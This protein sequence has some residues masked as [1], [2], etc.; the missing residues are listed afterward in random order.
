M[1]Y[2]HDP[3]GENPRNLVVNEQHILTAEN[4][5]DF[6]TVIPKFAPFF[7]NNFSLVFRHAAT[8]HEEPLKLGKDY[9]F[10]HLFAEASKSIGKPV[11][12][13]VTF[14]KPGLRGTLLLK[15]YQSLG[16]DWILDT[17]RIQAILADRI[18]NPRT[19][20]WD[21]V[22]NLPYRYPVINHDFNIRDFVGM[23]NVQ[24]VLMR[25]ESLLRQQT[26]AGLQEH[27]DDRENPHGVTKHQVQLGNVLNL[28]ILNATTGRTD[29]SD[30]FYVT[31]RGVRAIVNHELKEPF[32]RFVARRDNPNQVTAE[33]VNSFTKEQ[34]TALLANYLIKTAAA[35]DTFRFDNKTA[36]QFKTWV[37]EG[38][39]SNA[40]RLDGLSLSQVISRIQNS[41][42]NNAATLEGRNSQELKSWVL[43]GTAA[44]STRAYGLDRDGLYRW[45]G[46]QVWNAATLAGKDLDTI[47]AEISAGTSENATKLNG[48]T[49]DQLLQRFVRAAGINAETLA[50]LTLDGVIERV[51]QHLADHGTVRNATRFNGKTWDEVKAELAPPS[52][53]I[54][55]ATLEGKN[56]AQIKQ[57]VQNAIS[58]DAGT[59]NGQ[60]AEQII[61]AALS[62]QNRDALSLQGKSFSQVM[63]A[64]AASTVDNSNRLGGQ[65]LDQVKRTILNSVDDVVNPVRYH[66][67]WVAF[68]NVFPLIRFQV[69]NSAEHTGYFLAPKLL[70][71]GF[72]FLDNLKSYSADNS[73]D[74]EV[75]VVLN[76]SGGQDALAANAVSLKITDLRGNMS[77]SEFA[78]AFKGIG[79]KALFYLKSEGSGTARYATLYM[80]QKQ[81]GKNGMVKLIQGDRT[82]DFKREDPINIDQIPNINVDAIDP[83][84]VIQGEGTGVSRGMELRLAGLENTLG[85]E[86]GKVSTL[87]SWKG[88]ATGQLSTLQ[89]QYNTL[90]TG[91]ASLVQFN[92]LEQ[93]VNAEKTKVTQLQSRV[94]EIGQ[95]ATQF[96]SGIV[97]L[98]NDATAGGSDKALTGDAGKW[99]YNHIN[100]HVNAIW[101]PNEDPNT[102]NRT[103]YL[104]THANK[105]QGDAGFTIYWIWNYRYKAN[106]GKSSD[107]QFASGYMGNPVT[108]RADLWMRNRH[109]DRYDQ[110]TPWVRIDQADWSKIRDVPAELKGDL[111]ALV[112]TD[113]NSEQRFVSD[114]SSNT[115]F[116]VHTGKAWWNNQKSVLEAPLGGAMVFGNRYGIGHNGTTTYFADKDNNRQGMRFDHSNM[117]LYVTGDVVIGDRSVKDALG[118][119]GGVSQG[120][121]LAHYG[122]RDIVVNGDIGTTDLNDLNTRIN[123]ET[124]KPEFGVYGQPRNSNTSNERHYPIRQAGALL[125]LPGPWGGSQMYVPYADPYIYKRGVTGENTGWHPWTV[126]GAYVP[127]PG[128]WSIDTQLESDAG[129]NVKDTKNHEGW[130]YTSGFKIK[131][132]STTRNVAGS[133]GV[134]TQNSKNHD[135][136]IHLQSSDKTAW[137]SNRVTKWWR[138]TH[139]GDFVSPGDV[140]FQNGRSLVNLAQNVVY[141]TGNAAGRPHGHMHDLNW[142]GHADRQSTLGHFDEGTTHRPNSNAKGVMLNITS[143]GYAG[144]LL[145]D[146][147][148]G[149]LWYR[150]FGNGGYRSW[151]RV[152]HPE[153]STVQGKPTN[154]AGYGIT[155][156]VKTSGDQ[157]ISGKKAF[158]NG[159]VTRGGDAVVINSGLSW[160]NSYAI[161]G[162][163]GGMFLN[164]DF[165]IAINSNNHIYFSK[166]N[167]TH[168][169]IFD[170]AN[171]NLTMKGDLNIPGTG[172]LKNLFTSKADKSTTLDGYGITDGVKTSGNQSVAGV[173]TFTNGLVTTGSTGD[174]VK[175]RSTDSHGFQKTLIMHG[176]HTGLFNEHGGTAFGIGFTRTRK[177]IYL[178]GSGLNDNPFTFKL[179]DSTLIARGDVQVHGTG[180]IKHLYQTKAD[181]AT[182]LSGYGITDACTKV[183]YNALN[184][185]V[186]ELTGIAN[187]AKQKAE[188]ALASA[189]ASTNS[190][191]VLQSS[192]ATTAMQ[193]WNIDLSQGAAGPRT[194]MFSCT[195]VNANI[196]PVLSFKPSPNTEAFEVTLILVNT[197]NGLPKSINWR[198]NGNIQWPIYVAHDAGEYDN[199]VTHGGGRYANHLHLEAAE[200]D[201]V[202]LEGHLVPTSNSMTIFYFIC[203]G[204]K[205]YYKSSM[206]YGTDPT[207]NTL[208]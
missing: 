78:K 182:T 55:A 94:A 27:K 181:R 41:M 38:T 9:Y 51:G 18:H 206:K 138:F 7:L 26:Q 50:D 135:L 75:E 162:G 20:Y 144:N 62:R 159:V 140:W 88:T 154:L 202:R 188:Q 102:S 92:A 30:D 203:H 23:G 133:F 183:E 67:G 59:L 122:I 128:Q 111:S 141:K 81:H 83:T 114:V 197:S 170:V 34:V 89:S 85:Q 56:L 24:E 179:N 6:Q 134:L 109:F 112:R 177:E 12:G 193:G 127:G 48:K 2:P 174:H 17:Q 125:S 107:V 29:N 37:L 169:F 155:D 172:S 4:G 98:V 49:E 176:E 73:M 190:N 152:S 106:D 187:T 175:V 149:E 200:Y 168:G 104:T 58:G 153:W 79:E 189:G 3:T 121:S 66:S 19:T 39:A 28:P 64:V 96:R 113:K 171:G 53:P 184:S 195:H 132:S 5:R 139:E 110:W 208:R 137:N 129:Y 201:R 123:N 11:Y 173:K 61:Q 21:Q 42:S 60:S 186:T 31:P 13:S 93:T 40:S 207:M 178:T 142:Y 116:K 76:G 91:K 115:G 32:E 82:V 161:T 86:S 25:I 74:I 52:G 130:A 100:S 33:Q 97:Q 99:L 101:L 44:D 117:K 77:E 57:E 16:G 68:D 70:I 158:T 145:M 180:G 80:R 148:N 204:Q 196:D 46:T 143:G 120:D 90:N 65:S 146:G 192:T 164:N 108:Q 69:P 136:L 8:G 124:N 166:R 163:G 194:F 126:V 167:H 72:N 54:D 150:G 199:F 160:V 131:S 84:K 15:K 45:L 157:E 95:T 43:E 1:S 119:S 36:E 87:E 35:H 151:V 63:A 147:I 205:L 105:P 185:K 71:K 118:Q 22:A 10:T 47:K 156:A 14:L 198:A 165:G 103:F 191:M